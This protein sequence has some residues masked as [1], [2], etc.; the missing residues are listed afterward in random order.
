VRHAR[1][2]QIAFV[3]QEDLGFVNQASKSGGVNDAIAVALM[4]VTKAGSVGRSL[5]LRVAA[6]TGEFGQAG[7]GG[8]LGHCFIFL[9]SLAVWGMC[10]FFM[11][12]QKSSAAHFPY[13]QTANGVVSLA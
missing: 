6:A 3:V 11:L 13:C 9:C 12:V 10:R 4:R 1:A 2:K 5:R 8:E 7:V